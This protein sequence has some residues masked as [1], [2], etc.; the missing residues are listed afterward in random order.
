I[1]ELAEL[2]I[3]RPLCI[4]LEVL[5]RDLDFD[6]E[7]RAVG[8]ECGDIEAASIG[9]R[10]FEDGAE[11]FLDQDAVDPACDVG[12]RG[13]HLTMLA[14]KE[15]VRTLFR[16]GR[17]AFGAGS[18]AGLRVFVREP[19]LFTHPERPR[20]TLQPGAGCPSSDRRS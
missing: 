7:H 13:W 19:R 17:G 11:P 5:D 14:D 9:E 3:F 15:S 1:K 4:V 8:T 18:I 16:R 2:E 10:E 20:L 12:S 6:A